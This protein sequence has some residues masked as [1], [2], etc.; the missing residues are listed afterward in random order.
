V[1]PGPRL[2]VL[3]YRVS[4]LRSAT[5][6]LELLGADVRVT[7]DPGDVPGAEAVVL[8]GVGHFGEAM[9]RIRGLGLDRAVLRAADAGVPILGFC[10]GLQLLF[11][12]SEESPGATGIGVLPGPVRRL[13]TD[14]KLPHIG[15]STVEWAPGCGL[16][17][18]SGRPADATYYFV[19]TFAPEPEDDAL[20]LGRARHGVEFCAAAGRPGV[21]G[22]QFHPEK[23]SAAGLAL[24]GRWLEGVRAVSGA[25]SLR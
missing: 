14:R 18:E 10:V 5:K 19:H 23:S 24:L 25:P 16:A 20:V 8:P 11:E 1:T 4:N 3:D 2:A 7:G 13:R 21:T 17:P 12:E 15:W 9:R 22:L 6:A